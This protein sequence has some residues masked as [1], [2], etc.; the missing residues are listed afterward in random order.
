M[1]SVPGTAHYSPRHRPRPRATTQIIHRSADPIDSPAVVGL[2]RGL[3]LQGRQRRIHRVRIRRVR[4]T[5]VCPDSEVA[6]AG[7]NV[8]VTL[9]STCKGMRNS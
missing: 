6:Q 7:R 1:N 5:L 4:A 3:G 2:P 8:R 9:L